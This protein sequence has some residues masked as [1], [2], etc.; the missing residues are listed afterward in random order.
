[1]AAANPGDVIRRIVEIQLV[2]IAACPYIYYSDNRRPG[3]DAIGASYAQALVKNG[4]GGSRLYG[5]ARQQGSTAN[6][7]CT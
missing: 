6:N 2:T 1:V 7:K 5:D 4:H 3:L